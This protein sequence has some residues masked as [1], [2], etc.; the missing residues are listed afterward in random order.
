CSRRAAARESQSAKDA[1]LSFR[2]QRPRPHL[3]SI[4]PA[5]AAQLTTGGASAWRP[6]PLFLLP[7]SRRRSLWWRARCGRI[8]AAPCMERTSRALALFPGP[9]PVLAEALAR[10]HPK[11]REDPM[12]RLPAAALA[13]I[14]TASGA[15]AA[16][17]GASGAAGGAG[18]AGSRNRRPPRRAAPRPW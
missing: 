12:R 2:S 5:R 4:G 1:L 3:N 6:L 15:L 16:G 18:G 7:A 14:L 10:R 13:L 8:E 17:G 11:P 9:E